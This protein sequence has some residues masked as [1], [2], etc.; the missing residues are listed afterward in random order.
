MAV[1]LLCVGDIHLGRVLP[2]PMVDKLGSAVLSPATAWER[3]VEFAIDNE[4]DAVL[5]AGDV[6]DDIRDRFEALPKLRDGAERLSAAEIKLVA[7]AGNHDVEALPRLLT[8]LPGKITLLGENGTWSDV[9]VQGKSGERVRI[10]GWS[11]PHSKDGHYSGNPLDGFTLPDDA[12][13]MVGL[14]H[15]DLNASG[16]FYAPVPRSEINATRLSACF[17]GHIHRPDDLS[18]MSRPLGYLGSLCGLDATE[19]GPRGPWLAEIHSGGKV[20]MT[21]IPLSPMR[22]E[23]LEIDAGDI[24]ADS[25]E[26][27][28]DALIS[29]ISEA[30]AA[31]FAEMKPEL[32]DTIRAVSWDIALTGRSKAHHPI[33]EALE[34]D[35]PGIMESCGGNFDDVDFGVRKIKDRSTPALSVADI[36]KGVDA[37]AILARKILALEN[38]DPGMKAILETAG[39]NIPALAYAG[40]RRDVDAEIKD[41]E[42]LRAHLIA[43]AYDVLERLVAENASEAPK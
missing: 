33:V 32:G 35:G 10:V 16:G 26:D 4:V 17:L 18:A 15:A 11:F 25:A 19:T 30:M 36:A 2:S 38:R 27:A 23:V 22:W 41:D 7:V 13:P 31:E 6:V 43:A 1:K 29:N 28:A 20:S 39:K 3:A 5:L 12:V 24:S 34:N 9:V 8:L 40:V 14:L 42:T 21:H 37:A